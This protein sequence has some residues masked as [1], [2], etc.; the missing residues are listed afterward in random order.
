MTEKLFTGTLNHN[1]NINLLE[2][3]RL[4][5]TLRYIIFHSFVSQRL[6]E[7]FIHIVGTKSA[8]RKMK[9]NEGDTDQTTLFRSV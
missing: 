5:E 3:G 6:F 9:A 2:H 1:Q 8:L 7:K 4:L